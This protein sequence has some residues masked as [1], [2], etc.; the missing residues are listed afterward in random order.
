MYWGF[1]TRGPAATVLKMLHIR[2]KHIYIYIYIK[3]QRERRRKTKKDEL[4]KK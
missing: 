4:R 1:G 2:I 3:K